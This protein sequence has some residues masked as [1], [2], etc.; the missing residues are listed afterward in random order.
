MLERKF[1]RSI[2]YCLIKAERSLRAI[3]GT[4]EG[5]S[6]A[7]RALG[8]LRAQFEYAVTAEIIERGLHEYLDDFQVK[9]NRVGEAIFET[10]FAIAPADPPQSMPPPQ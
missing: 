4:P 8:S 7:E 10:F 2:L 3:T 6:L 5:T 1:P 9:L